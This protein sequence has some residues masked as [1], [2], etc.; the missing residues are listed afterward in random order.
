[1]TAS[2]GTFVAG[3]AVFL[4]PGPS[5]RGRHA[6][7]R[8]VVSLG[9]ARSEDDLARRGAD[10]RGHLGARVLH[11]RQR[12]KARSVRGRGRICL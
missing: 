11:A 10:Q 12:R 1:M 9:G 4:A 8:Q 3:E 7:Q 5:R 2:G 6:E